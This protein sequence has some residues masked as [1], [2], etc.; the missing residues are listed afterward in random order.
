MLNGR[1]HGFTAISDVDVGAVSLPARHVACLSQRPCVPHAD[2]FL[3]CRRHG[4]FASQVL[5]VST[6]QSP[7]QA[8]TVGYNFGSRT[9]FASVPAVLSDAQPA[10]VDSTPPL[11]SLFQGETIE[12]AVYVD[13]QL[14]E[15]FF[16]GEATIT[17][18][19]SNQV[20]SANLTTTFVNTAGLK[21]TVS[22]W[23]LGL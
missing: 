20:A 2:R 12:L 22:S 15:T 9:G 8:V 14:V 10:R 21:C 7:G 4:R 19:T 16:Q 1:R 23:A 17:T 6:L 5:G 18:A 13:G 3:H 11:T